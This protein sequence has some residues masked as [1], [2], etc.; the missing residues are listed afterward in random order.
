MMNILDGF[1]HDMHT[2]LANCK[3]VD[4]IRFKVTKTVIDETVCGFV[5]THGIKHVLYRRVF[6]KAPIVLGDRGCCQLLPIVGKLY[7]SH[8]L[9]VTKNCVPHRKMAPFKLLNCM[10]IGHHGLL[11]KVADE[12]V[13]GSRGDNIRQD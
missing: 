10:R 1:A 5:R 8:L 13:A 7:R 4:I 3:W 2:R 9:H 6:R 12:S 11:L